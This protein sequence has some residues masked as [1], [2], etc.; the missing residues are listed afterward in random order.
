MAPWRNHGMDN[1][2]NQYQPAPVNAM[3]ICLA[4]TMPDEV[5]LSSPWSRLII[6]RPEEFLAANQDQPV[7]LAEICAATGACE[8]TRRVCCQEYLGM[9]RSAICGCAECIWRI[10]CLSRRPRKRQR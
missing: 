6:A 10:V 4:E 5:H 7:Y 2:T 3:I 8:R 1:S 9:A